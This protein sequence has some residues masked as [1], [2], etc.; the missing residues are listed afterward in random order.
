MF[1]DVDELR[2]GELGQVQVGQLLRL[3]C[4]LCGFSLLWV[5]LWYL[6]VNFSRCR[7]PQICERL[8]L[9]PSFLNHPLAGR[10][11]PA[12]HTGAQQPRRRG[13]GQQ[14]A[15]KMRSYCVVLIHQPIMALLLKTK[16][17]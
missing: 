14:A 17:D 6:E 2:R 7:A 8:L 13:R 10:A 15:G 5:G 1:P 4:H 11:S 12:R 3:S 16:L 9:S